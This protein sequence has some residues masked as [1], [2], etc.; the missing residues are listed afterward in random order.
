M[1]RPRN[2]LNVTE[3]EREHIRALYLQGVRVADIVRRTK[4][5]DTVVSR[6]VQGMQR[7]RPVPRPRNTQRD[8]VIIKRVV[9]EGLPMAAVARRFRLT[10]PRVCEIVRIA[11]GLKSKK[12]RA[13]QAR[14]TLSTA[15]PAKQSRRAAT[16]VAPVLT[17][18]QQTRR[19][20]RIAQLVLDEHVAAALVARGFGISPAA[21]RRIVRL[22]LVS[23][24][25]ARH[26]HSKRGGLTG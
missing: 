21:V 23:H 18:A 17:R 8:K 15:Q 9:E 13:G 7:P 25:R 6:A 4:R 5:S 22:A 24:A 19:N 10:P 11:L 20:T 2:S 1:G 26:A 12:Q 14:S 3:Q 16:V